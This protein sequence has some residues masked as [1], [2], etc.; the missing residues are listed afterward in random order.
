VGRTPSY[1][2]EPLETDGQRATPAAPGFEQEAKAPDSEIRPRTAG[3]APGDAELEREY[4]ADL[5]SE[6]A[7]LVVAISAEELKRFDLDH[8]S[9]FLLSLLDGRTSV[10]EVLD[11]AGLPRLRG[12]RDLRSLMA[13]GIIAPASE[14]MTR[15]PRT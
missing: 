7:R 12:L 13:R 9:G 1:G 5:G 8:T 14:L 3:V 6:S 15:R 2:L 11:I 10:G 4:L